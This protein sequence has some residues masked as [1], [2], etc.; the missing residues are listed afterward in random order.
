MRVCLPCV[1]LLR[2]EYRLNRTRELRQARDCRQ[3]PAVA[4]L[5]LDRQFSPK[6][7]RPMCQGGYVKVRRNMPDNQGWLKF[8]PGLRPLAGSPLGTAASM[9][10]KQ[11]HPAGFRWTRQCPHRYLVLIPNRTYPLSACL[12]CYLQLGRLT[13]SLQGILSPCT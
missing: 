2:D 6:M 8:A 10:P 4:K 12:I 11:I 9:S 3:Q 1:V 13:L 7:S 5:S